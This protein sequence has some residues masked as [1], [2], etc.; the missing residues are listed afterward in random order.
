MT[1]FQT[2]EAI[3]ELVKKNDPSME[4]ITT[5]QDMVH[6]T[7]HYKQIITTYIRHANG[8]TTLSLLS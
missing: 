5:L 6:I 8:L 1:I 3:Y 2:F 4:D 7:C